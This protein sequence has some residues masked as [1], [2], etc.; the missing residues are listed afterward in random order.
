[1]KY[2]INWKKDVIVERFAASSKGGQNANKT[3]VNVRLTH[4]PTGIKSQA[5]SER[6]LDQNF[7]N[8][9]RVLIARIIEHLESL[10]ESKVPKKSATRG[11]QRRTYYLNERRKLQLVV[12]HEF[13]IELTDPKVMDGN[14]DLFIEAALRNSL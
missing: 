7:N 10:K 4:L 6:S 11:N 9:V 5:T 13:E 1:M 3:E 2:T 8:A 12:D 14:L